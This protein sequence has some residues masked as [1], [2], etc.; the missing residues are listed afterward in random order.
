MNIFSSWNLLLKALSFQSG[1]IVPNW[2]I[3]YLHIS[4]WC[5]KPS[6]NAHQSSKRHL[7]RDHYSW[8]FGGGGILLIYFIKNCLPCTS[9]GSSL[10]QVFDIWRSGWIWV[11]WSLFIPHRKMHNLKW[12]CILNPV[13]GKKK[14]PSFLGEKNKPAVQIYLGR[15]N[16]KFL[17]Y[18]FQDLFPP[19]LV[20][21]TPRYSGAEL[22]TSEQCS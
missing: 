10:F 11:L 9:I 20:W 5:H 2:V 15:S 21:S 19:A 3:N 18:F 14:I 6:I 1:Q 4:S 22:N 16:S 7:I 17:I 8:N 12:C 13:T